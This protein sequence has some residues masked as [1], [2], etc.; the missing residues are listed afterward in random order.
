MQLGMMGTLLLAMGIDFVGQL[1]TFTAIIFVH[2]AFGATQDVA[3]DALAVSV[4]PEHERGAANGFMFAG[5]SIG[6]TIG[7]SGVLFLTAVMPF[8]STYLFVVATIVAITLFVVVPLR[9]TA[10]PRL[11][12]GARA[13]RNVGRELAVFVRDAWRAF[14]GSRA[15]LVGVVYAAAAGGRLRAQPRPAIEPRRRARP[16]RQPG[17]AA[18]SLHDADFRAGVHLRRLAVRPLRATLDAL[19]LRRS[20]P[21]RRLSGSPG[22]CGRRAGSCRST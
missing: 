14:T 3:I 17:R 22:R 4:L 2:N 12:A 9:E 20:S 11:S 5:A 21:L 18:E 8:A 13:A 7:G 10:G 1:A 15:A 19:S 6:Q 16:R